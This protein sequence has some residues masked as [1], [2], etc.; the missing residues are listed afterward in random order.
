MKKESGLSIDVLKVDGGVTNNSQLLQFQSNIYNVAIQ[1]TV[2]NETTAI[3]SAYLAGLAVDYWTSLED[4]SQN[5]QVKDEFLPNM[6]QS[7]RNLLLQ[8]WKRA[9]ERSMNWS[10]V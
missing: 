10:E 9:L 1:K 2:I 8:T 7:E 3:W 5:F 6:N 4:I